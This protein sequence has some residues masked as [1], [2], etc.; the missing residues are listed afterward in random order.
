MFNHKSAIHNRIIFNLLNINKMRK[1]KKML[2]SV[3]SPF[4]S[5]A[6]P[7]VGATGVWTAPLKITKNI[8]YFYLRRFSE[9]R[10]SSGST[11]SVRPFVCPS[12]R[13]SVRL[14]AT[15]LGCIVCVICNSNS[16]HSFIFKLCLMIVHT[17][18][19]CTSYFVYI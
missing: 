10:S 4:I 1:C 12:V 3:P 14:S 5:F 11:P 17:L 7:R 6:D 18:K 13:L 16:F 9:S 8:V 15:L 2:N 19:M